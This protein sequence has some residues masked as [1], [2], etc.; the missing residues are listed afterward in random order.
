MIINNNKNKSQYSLKYFFISFFLIF[1]STAYANSGHKHSSARN[2][3]LIEIGSQVFIQGANFTMGDDDT[4]HEEGPSHE[5]TLTDFWIDAHEVTNKQFSKFASETGYITVAERTP[6]PKDWPGMPSEL[7]KPGSTLFVKPK[8]SNNILSW[9]SYVEG[10][11]WRHPYGPT[12]S[13]K[14]RDYY[15]VIHV[16]WEDAK[17]YADWAGR[18]LPTEAQ[19][20]LAARSQRNG[21]YAW[22]GEELAPKGHH[23]ANTWQGKFPIENIADDDHLGLA[24]VGCYEPNDYGAY[25]LIGN[26]WEWTSNW[27]LPRHNPLDSHNPIGPTKDQSHQ[28]TQTLIPL[29]VIK[30]G[31][32]LCAPN[33]CI[34][35]RPA[36]RQA[37]DT[38][39]GT[40][41]IGFRT[42]TMK[43]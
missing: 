38:G 32:F 17:A 15:P 4:Y 13:I 35:Y 2:T 26:V 33:Y 8:N 37:A 6:D 21:T 1:N 23:Y 11:N 20:E 16:A 40:S 19:F 41:H 22:D 9:W 39:L 12:S 34:R 27:Y 43:K 5:I 31:S 25:D 30:G 10:V 18:S 42:V 36:A 24:P 14:G 28:R 7:L 29:R 3:C